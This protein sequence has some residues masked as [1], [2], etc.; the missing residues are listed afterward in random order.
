MLGLPSVGFSEGTKQIAPLPGDSSQLCIDKSR[1]DFGFFD[2]APEFRI[3]IY[4]AKTTETINFGLGQIT[5][6]VPQ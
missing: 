3:N 2:A 1:N 4:I 5:S 6:P